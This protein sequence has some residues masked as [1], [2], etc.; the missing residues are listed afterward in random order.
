[1]SDV[2][3]LREEG[4]VIPNFLKLDQIPTNYVQQVET[5]LLEPVV[6]TQGSATRDGFTRFTLQNKGFLHSHSKLFIAL[7]PSANDENFIQPHVGIG[8]IVKKAVLKIGNKTSEST[9][10]IAFTEIPNA[11]SKSDFSHLLTAAATSDSK[12]IL[13]GNLTMHSRV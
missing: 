11:L 2:D 3:N 9:S 12:S 4:E 8:Q 13:A 1:M 6:F 10:R 7:A 5:D